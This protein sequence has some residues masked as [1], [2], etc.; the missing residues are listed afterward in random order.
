ML[1]GPT[2]GLNRH[3]V[4]VAAP[5][6]RA[7][8]RGGD[9]SVRRRQEGWVGGHPVLPGRSCQSRRKMVRSGVGT[10]SV[11]RAEAALS[12]RYCSYGRGHR[13]QEAVRQVPR[14]DVRFQERG[15]AGSAAARNPAIM[16]ASISVVSNGELFSGD[17]DRESNGIARALVVVHTGWNG[18]SLPRP[19][20][21]QGGRS[22]QPRV[23]II[24]PTLPSVA[25]ARDVR[26]LQGPS[27][28]REGSG[29]FSLPSGRSIAAVRPVAGPPSAQALALA[30]TGG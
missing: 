9:M 5:M 3:L 4:I 14:S 17:P 24:F 29:T 18:I 23:G 10:R 21:R 13:L 19:R 30:K 25:A 27:L 8:G 1:P 22:K 26:G 6:L 12:L 7:T 16:G 2:G 15:R 11:L 28:S 20:G